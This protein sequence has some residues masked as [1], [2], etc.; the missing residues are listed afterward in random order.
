MRGFKETSL[1]DRLSTSAKAKEAQLEK[2]RKLTRANQE[3]LP[4]RQAAR[5]AVA[6]DRDVRAA[7]RKETKRVDAD[8]KVAERVVAEKAR[9]ADEAAAHKAREVAAKESAARKIVKDADDK[10]ARDAR[11]AARKK[12]Q[13]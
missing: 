2:T 12:R 9:V 5:A 8:R 3:G 1:A 7:N 11:Y 13:R 10:K 6:A 4:Q